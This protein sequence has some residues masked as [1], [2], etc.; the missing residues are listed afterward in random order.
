M[1]HYT[2]SFI[3]I[4]LWPIYSMATESKPLRKKQRR[5]APLDITVVPPDKPSVLEHDNL[6]IIGT[7]I[8]LGSITFP[9]LTFEYSDVIGAGSYATVFK[10]KMYTPLKKEK[11]IAIKSIML[12]QTLLPSI[13]NELQVLSLHINGAIDFYGVSITNERLYFLL[14]KMERSCHQLKLPKN[15]LGLKIL[16]RL[17]T[18]SLTALLNLHTR[19]LLHLDIKPS[20]LLLSTH[21]FSETNDWSVKLADFGCSRHK[22]HGEKTNDFLGSFRYMSPERLKGEAYSFSADVWSLGI[23][24]LEFALG[25]YPFSGKVFVEILSEVEEID[26]SSFKNKLPHTNTLLFEFLL[27]CLQKDPHQRA[28]CNELLTHPFLTTAL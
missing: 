4:V 23:T 16:Q 20:N 1:M 26:F 14:E 27:A 3:I 10:G 17:A 21:T 22:E 2:L 8:K 15:T 12:S 28:S 25:R 24:L 6:S 9:K 13:A 19:Q 7:T 11:I 5:L 18:L